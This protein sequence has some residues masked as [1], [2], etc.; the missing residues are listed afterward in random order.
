MINKL[1]KL[2]ILTHPNNHLAILFGRQDFV[3]IC[4]YYLVKIE[5]YL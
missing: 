3:Q 1:I 2:I 4:P 5:V